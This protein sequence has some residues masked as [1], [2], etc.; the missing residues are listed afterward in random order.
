M[1]GTV[2]AIN[3]MPMVPTTIK[4]SLLEDKIA[5]HLSLGR[6]TGSSCPTTGTFL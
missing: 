6:L 2:T 1:I 5:L 3:E 4:M